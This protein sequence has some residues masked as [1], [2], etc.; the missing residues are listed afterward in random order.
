MNVIEILSVVFW[1]DFRT[2]PKYLFEGAPT[3]VGTH[4][5]GV[6]TQE[7]TGRGTLSRISVVGFSTGPKISLSRYRYIASYSIPVKGAQIMFAGSENS[8]SERW[9][10]GLIFHC[11]FCFLIGWCQ[12]VT[13]MGAIPVN[14]AQI[15]FACSETWN[16]EK[17]WSGL[18]PH[19]FFL[20]FD[21]LVSRTDAYGRVHN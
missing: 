21:W 14:G 18:I 11:F 1:T 5:A 9:W 2:C 19:C 17:W 8:N 12:E 20:L 7:L 13:G 16:S 4:S 15:M 10:S 6:T 3:I